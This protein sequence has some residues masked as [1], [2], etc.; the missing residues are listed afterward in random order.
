MQKILVSLLLLTSITVIN[1]QTKVLCGQEQYLNQL[2]Q[3]YPG[4]KQSV[5][6]AFATN[7]TAIKKTAA[8]NYVINVVFHVVWKDVA[9]NL[10][11][12]ILQSQIDVL[13]E[14]FNRLNADSVNLRSL[15]QPIAGNAK[16]TFNLAQVIRVKTDSLFNP[17]NS[18][19][20]NIMK[21]D[22]LGGSDALD[23]NSYLN[24]WICKIQPLTF[25]GIPIGQILGF[26]F[27]PANLSNWPANSA[28]PQPSE[29]GVVIDFR[30]IGRN[31]PN[32]VSV[33][34]T[35]NLAVKGRT[36]VHEIGHYLGLRHIWGDGGNPLTGGGNNC[37]GDDGI[38]DTPKANNQS[39]FDCNKLRNSCV[40]TNLPW[41]T[42]NPPDMIE[43]FMDYSAETCMNTFTKGQVEHMH[44]TLDG[45]RSTLLIPA[46][47]LNIDVIAKNISLYP[48]P[49]NNQFEFNSLVEK[50]EFVE[51]YSIVG[52]NVLSQQ[53]NNDKALINVNDLAKGIYSVKFYLP[54]NR[55][56]TKKLVI[57]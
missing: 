43:N 24:V 14:D 54:N 32:T 4:F 17:S 22:S 18:G 36:P 6:A 42:T 52:K 23:P 9:E 31:N 20:P 45:P 8:A 25:F 46:S 28:A 5:D 26:A 29:D 37:T 40:D 39:Q 49:A 16:I 2:E 3:K 50:I 7:T 38:A 12:S 55:S 47:V 30:C 51:L 35:N 11:D 1:A 10:H 57:N 48:N 34:G 19:I 13:N 53:I 27:P 44:N 56:V 15:F 21:H 33:D 41:T